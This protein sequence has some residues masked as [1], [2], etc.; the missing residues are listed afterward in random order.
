MYDM[1]NTLTN[2]QFCNKVIKELPKQKLNK[3]MVERLDS[4]KLRIP[5]R[6][7]NYYVMFGITRRYSDGTTIWMRVWH[8]DPDRSYP[9]NKTYG[10]SFFENR[11]INLRDE[12]SD[13]F[14]KNMKEI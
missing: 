4:T 2:T 9:N 12:K 5:H 3:Y 14:H 11:I 1:G 6:G 7:K 8:G 10:G 13:L